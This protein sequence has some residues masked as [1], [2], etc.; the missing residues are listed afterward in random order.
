M[1]NKKSRFSKSI[2][3]FIAALMLVSVFT[4]CGANTASSEN[5]QST[6]GE[7]AQSTAQ[8]QSSTSAPEKKS[9]TLTVWHYMNDRETLIKEMAADY[10]KQTGVKVDF[11][12]Y[13]GDQMSSK[14]QAAAQAKTLPEAWTFAGGLNDICRYAEAG[15][16][17]DVSQVAADWLTRFNKV[18]L[19]YVTVTEDIRK[20]SQNKNAPLGIYGI[21]LDVVNMQFLYNKDLFTKAG[22]DPEKPPTTWNELLDMGKKLKTAGIV[23]FATGVGSWAGKSLASIYMFA[24]ADKQK[25]VDTRAGKGKYADLSMDKVL[26]M[27]AEMRDAKILSDGIGT[28]DLPAAEQMFANGQAAILYDGSWAIGVLNGMNPNFKNYGVFYPPKDERASYNALIPGGI[29]SYFVINKES[30]NVN[31]T[32]EL[33]KWLTDN[34]QQVKYCNSSFNLPA[35]KDCIDPAK[36]LPQAAQFADDMDKIQPAI[37]GDKAAVDD[38]WGKGIQMVCIGQKNSADVVKE[39]DDNNK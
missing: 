9:V 35:N 18:I 15:N 29:G 17:L 8:Q 19:D 30:P 4:G 1:L 3:L 21:P 22:L 28:M 20:D 37:I 36:L 13:S 34:D 6:V 16:I 14:V 25:I 23:P 24:Y 5:T 27:F 33:M 7:K 2:S 31:E 39:M 26:N 38:V 32:L 10:E 12:L 11:Q